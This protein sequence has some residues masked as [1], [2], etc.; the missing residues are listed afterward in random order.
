MRRIWGAGRDLVSVCHYQ[1]KTVH[2]GDGRRQHWQRHP[3]WDSVA[4]GLGRRCRKRTRSHMTVTADPRVIDI[5]P[6][7]GSKTTI[8]IEIPP[9]LTVLEGLEQPEPG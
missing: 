9:E 1:Q 3:T 6:L 7:A 4:G 2:Q 8:P 5:A